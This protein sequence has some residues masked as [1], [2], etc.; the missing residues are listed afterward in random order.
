[1]Q[2]A[3]ETVVRESTASAPGAAD[4]WRRPLTGFARASDPFFESLKQAVSPA[5]R[6]PSEIL[7]GARTVIAFFL[8]FQRAVAVG[9]MGGKHPTSLWAEAYLRTNDRIEAVCRA[10]ETALAGKG[11][12][13]AFAPATGDF[14]SKT[15][16]STW[17]H[18]HVAVA[19]GL[20]T[21]GVHR[22]LI[23]ERGAAGRIGS[24]V[25]DAEI[26]PTPRPAEE[27]CLHRAGASCMQCVKN[28]VFGA[29][30]EGGFQKH[31]CLE[32]CRSN[33]KRFVRMGD[34]PVCGK[35]VSLTPC[36]FRRPRNLDSGGGIA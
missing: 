26:E 25:T 2:E 24:V 23:T 21:L 36:S 29:L 35:C 11:H 33:A 10:I 4:L 27:Y 34:A 18:K 8:P 16:A 6:L 31:R 20:G 1:M 28:C 30:D 3:I 5:H 14:D 15:L 13:S 22:M 12:R 32:V 7:E 17:S 9:N 19:A